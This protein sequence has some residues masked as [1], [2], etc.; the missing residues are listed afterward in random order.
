ME[1]LL[2]HQASLLTGINSGF[3]RYLF[4]KLP[5]QERF[6]GIKGLRGVG[7]TTLLLQHLKYN[8]QP[9]PEHL[10]VTLDHPYFYSNTLFELAQD[11][12]KLG[13]KTLLVDEIH[14]LPNW[15]GEL[16]IMYDGLPGLQVVFTASSALDIYRG[17]SDLSRRVLSYNLGGLSFRE[18]LQLFHGV[19]FP[20]IPLNDLLTHHMPLAINIMQQI[21]PL[22]LFKEYLVRG[23]FPFGKGQS[24]ESFEAR[25]LQTIEVVMNEDLAFVEGYSADHIYKIKKLLGV[26]AETTPFTAN[27]SSIADKLG[28]GRNT[29]TRHLHAMEKAGILNFLNREGK[30]ISLLQKPDKMFTENTNFSY[31]LK[32]QPDR[33]TLRETFLINQLKNAGFMLSLPEKGDVLITQKDWSVLFEIGGK[34]KKA[35]QVEGV[36]NSY[37]IADDIESG[38]LK[39]IPLYLFGF[40]Y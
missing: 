25:L 15:S 21:K 16:K 28:I 17:A 22:A 35:K 8:L 5:W 13:G 12:Y 3:T 32:Y 30:G 37:F 29:V 31:V 18:Y 33:G 1:L 19:S 2:Q 10:Y 4:E 24:D 20:V 7:K 9:T 39:K 36:G 11:F 6:I 14:K 26:L 27:I 38:Y 34:D 40:L 23:Y